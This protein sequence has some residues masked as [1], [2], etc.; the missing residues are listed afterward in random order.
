MDKFKRWADAAKKFDIDFFVTADGDDLFYDVGLADLVFQQY[1]RT[2]VDFI[3]GQGLYVDI[4]GVK[5]SA[6]R[7]MMGSISKNVK[8]TEPFNLTSYF[9]NQLYRTAN[10]ENVPDI[11]KKKKIRMTLDYDDDFKFFNTVINDLPRDFTFQDVL[12]ALSVLEK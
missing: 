11:Y 5:V 10:L 6:L 9:D 7:D 2:N 8:E 4:Y 3:N 1:E 12:Q